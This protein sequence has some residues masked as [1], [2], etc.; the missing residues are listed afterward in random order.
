MLLK[1]AQTFNEYAS[2]GM[3]VPG[4]MATYCHTKLLLAAPKAQKVS[5]II[6]KSENE[7]TLELIR[8]SIVVTKQLAD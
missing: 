6:G 2:T 5:P 3:L 8:V 7:R 1:I 4:L